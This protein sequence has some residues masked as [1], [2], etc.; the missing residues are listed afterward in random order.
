MVL[1]ALDLLP[2]RGPELLTEHEVNL[3]TYPHGPRWLGYIDLADPRGAIPDV[4]DFKTLS[5]KRY[6]KTPDELR[7]SAQMVA[8]AWWA[9]QVYQPAQVSVSHIYMRTRNKPYA[10]RVSVILDADEIDRVWHEKLEVVKK[11]VL[12]ARLAPTTAEPLAPNT[13]ACDMYGGCPF[14][15]ECGLTVTLKKL[16]SGEAKMGSLTDRLMAKMKPAENISIEADRAA[17]NERLI[18]FATAIPTQSAVAAPAAS[19]ETVTSSVPVTF[20]G[21]LPPDAPPR[22][23]IEPP[24]PPV[25][26]KKSRKRTA[27]ENAEVAKSVQEALAF[28]V[29]GFHLY[30]DALPVKGPLRDKYVLFE[31]FIQPYAKKVAE[32][33]GIDDWRLIDFGKGAVALAIMIRTSIAE[34]PPV[35]VVT[36]HSPGAAAVL[37]VLIPH[38]ASV[39][40]ALKG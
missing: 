6:M 9:L 24:A 8:Y 21:I 12:W 34:V 11:M 36:S 37:D 7:Q 26:E 25:E 13:A 5:D 2:E 28:A 17:T 4:I 39:V 14:R 33:H 35:L 23:G 16:T 20:S 22:D 38:A 19:I 10:E 27:K 31:D 40:R 3:V 29:K 32:E 18:E 30:I 15:R 1:P